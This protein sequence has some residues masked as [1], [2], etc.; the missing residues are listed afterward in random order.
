MKVSQ[1]IADLSKYDPECEIEASLDDMATP[2]D[3]RV[4]CEV[5][6]VNPS[7]GAPVILIVKA[8][9]GGLC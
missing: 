9:E 8:E 6:G 4:F 2:C 1:L 7:L 5:I 3:A